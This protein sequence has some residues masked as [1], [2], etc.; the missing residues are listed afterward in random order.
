[1]YLSPGRVITK[2]KIIIKK[3]EKLVNK[4]FP[5]DNTKLSIQIKKMTN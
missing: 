4:N 3:R 5:T 2:I 1:M